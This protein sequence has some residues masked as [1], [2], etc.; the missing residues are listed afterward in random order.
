MA[1]KTHIGNILWFDQK[2]G[3]GFLKVVDPS[4]EYNE[5]E[6]FF[7]YSQINCVNKFKKVFPG[8]YVSL[9]IVNV[10]E[11]KERPYNGKKISGVNGGNLLIDHEKYNY[12]IYEK[13][14]RVENVDENTDENVEK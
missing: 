11:D 7:H 4:S 14:R 13:K 1:E 5:K 12:K 3:F 9:D 8:E 10:E 6:I 2:K